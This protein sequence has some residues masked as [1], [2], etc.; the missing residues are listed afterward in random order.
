MIRRIALFA[1]GLLAVLASAEMG[2]R[3]LGPSLPD[4]ARWPSPETE[5]KARQLADLTK[6]PDIVFL[7][8]SITEAAVDP[9]AIDRY[10]DTQS[11][12]AALPFGSPLALEEWFAG[13]VLPRVDPRVVVVGVSTWGLGSSVEND[14]L[15]GGLLELRR[16]EEEGVL[17]SELI[18]R[19]HQLRQLPDLLLSDPSPSTLWTAAGHQTAYYDGGPVASEDVWTSEPVGSLSDNLEALVR[20]IDT[21]RSNGAAAVLMIEPGGCPPALVGCPADTIRDEAYAELLHLAAVTGVPVIDGSL[22]VAPNDWYADSAH[23]NARGTK[24]FSAYVADVL[25]EVAP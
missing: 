5:I 4:R 13:H 7:G 20:L 1:I 22:F 25:G 9:A 18:E 17:K 19:R 10:L 23:F 6:S 15:L 2:V 3:A 16:A 8:T 21:V 12:N 24:E 14:P 11:Y